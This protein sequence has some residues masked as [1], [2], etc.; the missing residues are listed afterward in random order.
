MHIPS[1]GPRRRGQSLVEFSLVAPV[2]IMILFL[3]IDFGRLIY[4]FG[5][6]SWATREGARLISLAPQQATDC[7]VLKRVEQ[8]GQGF[9]L[10]PDPNSVVGN[11]DPNNPGP[12][13]APTTNDLIPAGQGYIYIWPAVAPR[14]PQDTNCNGNPRKVS[15]TARDVSVQVKY[16]WLPLMPVVSSIVPPFTITTISVVHT[17]Y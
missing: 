10:R 3:M 5:A 12:P 15:Q 13:L 2:L 4:T 16:K 17:E 8:V 9:P 1:V 14:T 6:I 7:A 11:T